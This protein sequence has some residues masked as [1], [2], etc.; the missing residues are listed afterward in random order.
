LFELE[1]I[2]SLATVCLLQG[3][4]VAKLKGKILC[5]AE[6]NAPRTFLTS[7]P[8]HNSI[9]SSGSLLRKLNASVRNKRGENEAAKVA[10]AEKL[11]RR[12]AES[13]QIGKEHR[14]LLVGQSVTMMI[15]RDK[16]ERG[17]QCPFE[18]ENQRVPETTSESLA[19]TSLRLHS[20]IRVNKAERGFTLSF[21]R[22]KHFEYKKRGSFKNGSTTKDF[23]M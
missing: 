4:F 2:S 16:D 18:I 9:E 8:Q 17:V 13:V 11:T 10:E 19:G 15:A 12:T 1:L 21:D 5:W 20:L 22:P 3:R 23:K 7:D 14:H 6:S